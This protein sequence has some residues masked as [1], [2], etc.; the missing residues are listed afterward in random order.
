MLK[1]ASA[2]RCSKQIPIDH[3]KNRCMY[4]LLYST[5]TKSAPLAMNVRISVGISPAYNAPMPIV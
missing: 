1:S 3:Q 2:A 4:N 5:V